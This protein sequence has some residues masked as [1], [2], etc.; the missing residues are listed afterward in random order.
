MSDSVYTLTNS[1]QCIPQNGIIFVLTAA[2]VKMDCS[3]FFT[4]TVVLEKVVGHTRHCVGAFP[5]TLA[6]VNKIED[7]FAWTIT[8]INII[9]AMLVI[10]LSKL[11]ML[12]LNK[13]ILKVIKPYYVHKKLI[14]LN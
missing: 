4:M 2:V 14:S 7:L 9:L 11:N 6:L 13:L 1:P 3:M 8:K 12:D 10:I 5:S